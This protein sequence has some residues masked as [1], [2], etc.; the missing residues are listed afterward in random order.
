[1]I[2]INANLFARVA[3]AQSSDPGRYYIGGVHVS[4]HP[5]GTGVILAA[6]D[7]HMMLVAYDASGTPPTQEGGHIVNL[8][9]DGLKTAAKGETVTLDPATPAWITL[10]AP[11]A[12][13]WLTARSRTGGAS[14]RARRP[15]ARR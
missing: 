11:P 8:G 15:R 6:T 3:M 9:K 1:M 5:S 12:R 7:G 13:P 14:C 4:A 10:G 2:Q